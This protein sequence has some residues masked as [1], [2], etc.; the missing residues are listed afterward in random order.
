MLTAV[1]ISS[2][3]TS[4]EATK[5]IFRVVMRLDAT[6]FTS[7]T[8]F[9]FRP[10]RIVPSPGTGTEWPSVAQALITSPQAENAAWRAPFWIPDRREASSIILLSERDEYF[11][12]AIWY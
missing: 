8:L 4:V 9:A 1:V 10:N 12:A 6:M 5:I 3:F 2:F 7:S 11:S